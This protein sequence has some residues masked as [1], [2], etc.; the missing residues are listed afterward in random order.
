M[1]FSI[2]GEFFISKMVQPS[3]LA[4]AFSFADVFAVVFT[5]HYGIFLP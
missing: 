2:G 5:K 1:N 3:K 4:T